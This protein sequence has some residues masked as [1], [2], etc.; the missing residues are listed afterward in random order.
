VVNSATINGRRGPGVTFER[1][2]EASKGAELMVMART[3]DGKWWQVCCLANQPFWVSADLVTAEGPV[4]T[5]PVLTPA[6]TPRPTPRPPATATPSPVPTP[7]PPFDV[8]RGPERYVPRDDGRLILR[9]K[10]FE[11]KSPYEK[12][13]PG[14]VV[15]VFRDGVDVTPLN[16]ALEYMSSR[17]VWD[18]TSFGKTGNYEYNYK[19]EM[20]GGGQAD[21]EIYLANRDG[22][23]VSLITKFTTKGDLYRNLEVYMSYWL[24]R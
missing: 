14:Y 24:A 1:L 19:F 13:L 10:V 3:T 5:V 23:R 15:K 7:L 11:G 12:P 8:A 22:Y 9:A 20:A 16:E 17:D 18:Y 21:W 6:P 2:G 4:D